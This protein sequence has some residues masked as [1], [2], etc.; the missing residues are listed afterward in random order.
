MERPNYHA[1]PDILEEMNREGGY[2][3][4]ILARGDGLLVA[5]AISPTVNGDVVAA[6]SGIMASTAE[7]TR[8]ELSL[9][10]LRDITIRCSAGKIVFK[11]I[12][13]RSD[14]VFIL[15]ALM[16]RRVRYHQRPLG[17]TATRIARLLGYK[18]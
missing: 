10:A 16:P 12:M 5:S 3:A 2:T 9:G 13:T 8:T 1:L 15:A 11:K 14:E 4:S 18:R 6:M 17:K 7:R